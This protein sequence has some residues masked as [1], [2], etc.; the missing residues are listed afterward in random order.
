VLEVRTAARD[1]AGEE[2][3]L[4]ETIS[5]RV[6]SMADR[7]GLTAEQRTKIRGVRES[8]AGKFQE[9]RAQRKALRGEEMKS[10]K[11]ILTPAQAEQV[12]DLVEERTSD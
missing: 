7:L 10:L 3:A 12:K 11:G 8:M 4:R 5:E 2:G 9:Q 1:S 6:E